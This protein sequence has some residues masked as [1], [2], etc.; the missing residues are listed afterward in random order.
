MTRLVILLPWTVVLALLVLNP[1]VHPALPWIVAVCGGGLMVLAARR[2]AGSPMW[3]V[4]WSVLALAAGWWI[5]AKANERFASLDLTSPRYEVAGWIEGL[6]EQDR[7]GVKLRVRPACLSAGDDVCAVKQDQYGL[8]PI[9]V[10]VTVPHRLLATPPLPGQLWQFQVRPA[11]QQEQEPFST[12]NLQRW[13]KASHVVARFRVG[14]GDGAQLLDAAT[15]PVQMAR[16]G[17][18]QALKVRLDAQSSG[19]GLSGLPVVLA[20]VTGDR[21]LMTQEHWRIFNNTGTTHLIA[22]SGAHIMLVT[23][24]VVWLFNLL[25]KRWTWLTM[26]VPSVQIALVLGWLVALGYGA[27]AGLGFPVQRA[28]IMLTLV[29]LFR[30]WGRAQPLWLAWNIA[31][32]LVILWDPMAV[33]SLGFWLSFIA[34]YWIIWMAGGAVLKVGK[35]R[36]WTRV[37]LGIFF[38]LAPVLLWQLQNLSLVSSVTNLFAIPLVGLVLTPLSLLWALVFGLAGIAAD[39]LLLPAQWLAEFTILLLQWCADTPFSVLNTTPHP[40]W[41]MLLALLG[42]VWLCTAG[43]PARWLAPVLCLP[44]LLPAEM[45]SGVQVLRGTAAPRIVIGQP[46]RMLLIGKG[47]WPALL[48]RWQQNLL[49]Y[50]GIGMPAEIPVAGAGEYWSASQWTLTT[51]SLRR[52]WLGRD[53]VRQTFTDLCRPP[54]A[55]DPN[56]DLAW[57]VV[58]R[59]PKG[60]QCAVLLQWQESRLL[61][62]SSLT[63]KAQQSLLATLKTLPPVDKVLLHPRKQDR[64]LPALVRF[65]QQDGVELLVTEL[66]VPAW[67]DPLDALALRI[68][69]LAESG[70][71]RLPANG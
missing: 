56:L 65:W 70:P 61:L 3:P 13:L 55:V 21:A 6:P 51:L 45:P 7:F 36:M 37:Q 31:F 50:Q 20:L 9:L 4:L 1:Q 62:L 35:V 58:Y 34:V 18:R 15:A 66:P 32:F 17:L 23:G 67:R 19:A 26:R 48:P 10:D 38:G 52:H 43:L 25:L 53:L 27:I 41:T 11:I 46:D 47:E 42:V 33:F 49:R 68:R 14:N 5:A 28:L 69:V 40:P 64:L 44:L 29:V 54:Q 30:V 24:V 39:I 22:I 59:N 8:W 63:Q 57:Q 2:G 71:L 60:T 16:L 12:F